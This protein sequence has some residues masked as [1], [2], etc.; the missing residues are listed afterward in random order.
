VCFALEISGEFFFCFDVI[1]STIFVQ[2]LII[3]C[4]SQLSYD[5]FFDKRIEIRHGFGTN[6]V[7]AVDSSVNWLFPTEIISSFREI[8]AEILLKKWP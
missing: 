4:V 1:S 8:F 3:V 5:I 2:K 6:S 7:G